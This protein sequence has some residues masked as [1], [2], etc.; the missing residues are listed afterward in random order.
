[1]RVYKCDFCFKEIPSN[2]V[3]HITAKSIHTEEEFDMCSLCLEKIY[4]NLEKAQVK[5]E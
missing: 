4:K 1:M 2:G 3:I 5:G